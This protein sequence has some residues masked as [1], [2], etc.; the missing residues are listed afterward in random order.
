MEDNCGSTDWDDLT[1]RRAGCSWH[2]DVTNLCGGLIHEASSF[3][4]TTAL[5]A[6]G[7]GVLEHQVFASSNFSV[8]RASR[9]VDTG[10][11]RNDRKPSGGS[12]NHR[13]CGGEQS[14]DLRGGYPRGLAVTSSKRRHVTVPSS[15]RRVS[16]PKQGT[17]G[18]G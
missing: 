2:S 1:S 15:E 8:S 14:Q 12:R 6:T 11:E 16:P 13:D 5:T 7:I 18:S 3:D 10:E 4:G 9:L 17:V